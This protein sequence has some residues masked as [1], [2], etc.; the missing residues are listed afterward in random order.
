[1][2]ETPI[3]M[4]HNGVAL[5]IE[6]QLKRMRLQNDKENKDFFSLQDQRSLL[7]FQNETSDCSSCTS[8]RESSCTADC[9]KKG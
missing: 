5:Y 8:S 1:M 9:K 7:T 6:L 3:I 4:C 2:V